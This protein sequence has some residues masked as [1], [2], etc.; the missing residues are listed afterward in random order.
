MAPFTYC[1]GTRLQIII[2]TY[3]LTY[4]VYVITADIVVFS[5]YFSSIISVWVLVYCIWYM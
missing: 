2:F 3:S 5:Y 4:V 1:G